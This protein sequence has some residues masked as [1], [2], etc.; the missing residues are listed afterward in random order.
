MFICFQTYIA[1]SY[2]K[3]FICFRC[4]LQVCLSACCICCSGYTH[5]LQVYVLN[6]SSNFRHILQQVFHVASVPC[7]KR[8]IRRPEQ[9][10]R[11][12]SL[13][14]ARYGACAGGPHM[15]A[16]SGAGAGPSPR[17]CAW[18]TERHRPGRRNWHAVSHVP[19]TGWR[20][21]VSRVGVGT[22]ET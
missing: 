11:M 22:R 4:L 20:H 10:G 15:H 21:G 3:C 18:E 2:L 19:C 1:N 16:R 7:F 12:D 17:A 9:A 13:V 8:W 5:M 14:W 6:I